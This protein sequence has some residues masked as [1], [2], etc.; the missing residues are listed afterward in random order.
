MKLIKAV[1]KENGIDSNYDEIILMSSDDVE[2]LKRKGDE[3]AKAMGCKKPFWSN[4]YPVMGDNRM[5]DVQ[6][7]LMDLPEECFLVITNS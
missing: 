5:E 1:P 3:I 6:E 2:T 7:F 4:R